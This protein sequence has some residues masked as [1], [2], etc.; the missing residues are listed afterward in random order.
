MSWHVKTSPY[1]CESEK[2]NK[3]MLEKNVPEL[4]RMLWIF[5]K[6]TPGDV[7]EIMGSRSSCAVVWPAD[8]DEKYPDVIRIGWSD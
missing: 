1:K 6:V 3:G 5:S 4:D 7:I 2:Q 8:E